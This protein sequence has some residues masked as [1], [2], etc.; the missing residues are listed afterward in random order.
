MDY[1]YVRAQVDGLWN[2]TPT[3]LNPAVMAALPGKQFIS[4]FTAAVV[5]LAFVEDLT[6]GEIATLDTAVADAIAAFDALPLLKATKV[7]QIRDDTTAFLAR[8]LESGGL[9]YA[10][11]ERGQFEVL[12]IY[13]LGVL[14]DP[15]P[16]GFWPKKITTTDGKVETP[17]ANA[18][19][20]LPF[21]NDMATGYAYWKESG[22][23]LRTE[24]N[25]ATT[26][27]EIDAVVDERTW[28]WT[29]P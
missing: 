3:N 5:V 16:A 7:Q 27:A 12:S 8:G 2:L 29:P 11:T 14:T 6:A 19:V 20:F 18:G 17:F 23:A 26:K 22:Q 24:V 9:I 28:P 25:E 21:F 1:N 10:S 4:R 13:T 15:A